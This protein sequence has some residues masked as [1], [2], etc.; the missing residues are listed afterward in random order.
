MPA[1]WAMEEMDHAVFEDER[2]N[3]R[4]TKLLSD[5]GERPQLSIPAACGGHAETAAA[6]RFF[7]NE[8]VTQD[9]VLQPHFEKT[10]ERMAEHSVVL[11]VQDTTELDFTRPHQQVAGAGPLKDTSQRGALLHPLE[12][13]V[14]AQMWT[15][16]DEAVPLSRKQKRRLRWTSPLEAKE[17]FRWLQGLRA[18]RE[19]AQEAPQTTFVCIGDSESDIYELFAE[20]RGRT[21][22]HW[23]IRAAQD[24]L[25]VSPENGT[26][27]ASGHEESVADESS[28]ISGECAAARQI[29]AA[30]LASPVLFQK[31]IS[32]RGR[33]Q[34][35]RCKTG[36]RDQ[37]R[38]SRQAQ[39][40]VRATAL[41]LRPPSRA[42]V[43]LIPVTVNVVLASEIDPPAGE[44]SVEWLL[45]TTLPTDTIE[46]V[47]QIL[48]YYAARFMIE[49]LFRVLKSGCRVEERRFEQIDRLLP[50][51]AVY[52]IVAW[53]TLM[54]CR[55]SR[56]WP[57]RDCEAIFEPAEW[58]SVWRVL[59]REPLPATPPKLGLMIRLMA[60][61]G[62]YVN[63][64]GRHDPPGPQTVWLGLQRT[65]DLAW[66]WNTF[67]PG[68]AAPPP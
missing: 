66:A 33:D 23:L 31:E 47:R 56:S 67:G 37:P 42:H 51:V 13:A 27:S 20:P 39:V 59:K 21:P 65:R 11:L 34:K 62:G 57:D 50:C 49:V 58:K 29:R 17:S 26:D 60:Q 5:L 10:R 22:V 28:L 48:Q 2:L 41:Q 16:E 53:R 18:A 43:E 8:S 61:L 63:H 38:E 52:L 32:V 14:W 15:R 30:A 54:V 3:A 24:R 64:P 55:L 1:A 4:L 40:E 7:D 36:S 45:I 44:V 25:I 19:V 12:G 46:H 68:A 9:L 35:I 6:Y